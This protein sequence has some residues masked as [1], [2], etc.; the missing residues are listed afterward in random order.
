MSQAELDEASRLAEKLGELVS[1]RARA[2][3][4]VEEGLKGVKKQVED[5]AKGTSDTSR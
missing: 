4:D 1:E 2:L 3:E 5:R